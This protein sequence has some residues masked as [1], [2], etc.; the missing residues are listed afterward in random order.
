M[1][2]PS[3]DISSIASQTRQP[4]LNQD[5]VGYFTFDFREGETSYPITAICL[6]DGM[7]TLD[8]PQFASSLA[9]QVALKSFFISDASWNERPAEMIVAA[10]NALLVHNSKQNLGTTL[11]VLLAVGDN[12]QL[13]NLGDDRIYCVSKSAIRCLT[14]DH[15]RLAERLGRNPT[16]TEVKESQAS[17]KLARS[18]GEKT[19]GSDYV[20]SATTQATAGDTFIVCTDG[21]WTEFAE[22]E[23]LSL[24]HSKVD[25]ERFVKLALERDK[26][27]DI[28]VALLRF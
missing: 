2:T 25:S 23:L 27:D 14:R 13:A 15:S 22:D 5:S 10:N 24:A 3:I 19:F 16:N 20:F 26:T 1:R 8:S 4:V 12:V 17:K 11:S 9:V 6:A 18:L 7:T 21:L 28:S